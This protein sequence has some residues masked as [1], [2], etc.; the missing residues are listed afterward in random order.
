MKFLHDLVQTFAYPYILTFVLNSCIFE[1]KIVESITLANL[2]I[3]TKVESYCAANL[4][5]LKHDE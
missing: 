4:N 5:Y 2:E 1:K 3:I